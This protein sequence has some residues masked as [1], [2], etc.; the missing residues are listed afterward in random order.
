LTQAYFTNASVLKDYFRHIPL[1]RGGEPDEVAKAVAFLASDAA[2]FITGTTLIVDGGQL[3]T[4]YGMWNEE[5]AEFASD[6]WVLR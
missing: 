6:H 5:N 3:A 1:G 4:K 2:S